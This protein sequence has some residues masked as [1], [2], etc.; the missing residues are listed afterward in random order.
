MLCRL[1]VSIG[2]FDL[3]AMCVLLM[4]VTLDYLDGFLCN[5]IEMMIQFILTGVK[6]V[7]IIYDSIAKKIISGIEGCRVQAFPGDI[8]A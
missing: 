8:I 5:H 3:L 4:R 7:T 2:C 1:L 6:R